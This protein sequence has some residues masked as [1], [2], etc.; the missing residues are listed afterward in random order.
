MALHE[1]WDV[2]PDTGTSELAGL[3]GMHVSSGQ[4]PHLQMASMSGGAD[5]AEANFANSLL[6]GGVEDAGGPA[7]TSGAQGSLDPG[8]LVDNHAPHFTGAAAASPSLFTGPRPDP[9]SPDQCWMQGF[10]YR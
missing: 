4:A 2:G 1:R 5:S 9:P 10:R 6:P 8:I 7:T 3:T